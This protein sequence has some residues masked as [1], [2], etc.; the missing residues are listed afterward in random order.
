MGEQPRTEDDQQSCEHYPS[1]SSSAVHAQLYAVTDLWLVQLPSVGQD[2][3]AQHPRH[4]TRR[5]LGRHGV[6][7]RVDLVESELLRSSVS[8]R[9]CMLQRWNQQY[10]TTT[11]CIIIQA[12]MHNYC[13]SLKI[14]NLCNPAA[15]LLYLYAYGVFR[16]TFKMC[17]VT[18]LK[19]IHQTALMSCFRNSVIFNL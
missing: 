17:K 4:S 3:R 12:H 2:V 10:C 16:F 9:E 5:Q 1:G 13:I 18:V 15:Y 14:T 7:Q 8:G 6:W 19:I 11:Y